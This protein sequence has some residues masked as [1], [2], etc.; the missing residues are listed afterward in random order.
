MSNALLS[1]VSGLKAH[2]IMLDA[3]GNNLAN[4]NTTAFK[5]SRV[6]FADLL[7][8]TLRDASQPSASTGGTNPMQVGSG[9]AVASIDRNILQGSLINTG[10]PLDMALEG[11]GYFVLNDGQKDVYT[12]VGSFAV[13][14][15][16]YLVDPGTGHRVQRIG[17]EGETEGFQDPSSNDIRIPFDVSLPA[18]QTETISYTGHLQADVAVPT[19]NVLCSMTQYTKDGGVASA[20]TILAELDQT[21]GIAATGD[22]IHITG[23]D[24]DGNPV[25]VSFDIDAATTTVGDLLDAISGAF[26]G[27]SATISDGKI[28]LTDDESGYS[29]TDVALEYIGKGSFDL[30]RYFTIT[31]AGGQLSHTTNIEIFDSQGASHILTGAFV[32]TN[33]PNKWDLV[34]TSITGEVELVDRRVEG[35][36]FLSNGAYGGLTGAEPDTATFKVKFG[37]DVDSIRTIRLDLGTIGGFDGLSQFGGDSTAAASGQDGYASG[38]LLSLSVTR[39]GVLVGVF[40]N[41]VRRDLA[42]LKLATFQNPAGLKSAGN[43]YYLASSNS[44]NPVP[45]RALSGAA[46]AVTGGS[47]EKSNVDV[48]AEFVNLIQAQNGFQANARTI[49]VANEMLQELTNLI[50]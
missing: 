47:L 39:E 49:R 14:A 38:T 13:D 19:T 32:R 21:S 18:Q 29:Q 7:S 42:A 26:S 11:N 2:Q 4:V 35:I 27:A 31:S 6:T 34:L 36:T 22:Q 30:P 46:G 50:R 8:E 15:Q 24:R 3:A 28:Y 43:G 37:H 16:Y 33:T 41:G 23:T 17:S 40:T 48:A 44:G 12:R 1:G 25:D 10:Q 5:A 45:T 20:D 9:V